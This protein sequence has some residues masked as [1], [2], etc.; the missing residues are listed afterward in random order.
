MDDSKEN[1]IN[2]NPLYMLHDMENV[3]EV[4]NSAELKTI[5]NL[6]NSLDNFNHILFTLEEDV[7]KNNIT[8]NDLKIV[9]NSIIK[10]VEHRNI[11]N[12]KRD[13]KMGLTKTFFELPEIISRKILQIKNI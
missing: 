2:D 4:L 11:K 8:I 5:N 7:V 12:I 3:Q 1:S 10:L 6:F 9:F 13:K